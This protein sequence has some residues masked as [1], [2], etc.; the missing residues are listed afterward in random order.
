V[1]RTVK[2]LVTKVKLVDSSRSPEELYASFKMLIGESPR[3]VTV[4]QWPNRPWLLL[5]VYPMSPTAWNAKRS[6][7]AWEHGSSFQVVSDDEVAM[8]QSGKASIAEYLSAVE[9]WKKIRSRFDL[10]TAPWRK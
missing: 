7:P 3:Y 4:H 10:S 5:I 9:I 8:P 1:S 6:E 2:S